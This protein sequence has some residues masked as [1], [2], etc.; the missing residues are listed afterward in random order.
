MTSRWFYYPS[1]S[2]DAGTRLFCVPYAG[3]GTAVFRDWPGGLPGVEVGVV[4]LPGR[5]SRFRDRPYSD[6]PTLVRDLADVLLAETDGRPYALF[7]HSMGGRIV[8]EVTR[9]IR[10]LGGEQPSHLF[11]SGCRAPQLAVPVATYDLPK[12]EFLTH[13]R[14]MGGAPPEFFESAE[15]IDLL[16]PV[17]RADF[18]VVDTYAYVPGAPLDLPVHA[19]HGDADPQMAPAD[20]AG[21]RAQTTG[22]YQ[23]TLVA[24][25]HFFVHSRRGEL[26]DAIAADLAPAL[27]GAPGGGSL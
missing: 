4:R 20:V 11:V 7:G 22:R 23:E 16:L 10:Q 18:A 13:L 6:M 21:W 25:D 8:F 12:A 3:G 15:L 9:R 5:E 24:G 26:V 19:F 14:T 1:P 27:A 2:A 17:V